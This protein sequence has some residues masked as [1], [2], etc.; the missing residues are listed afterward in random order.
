M[1][2]A[3]LLWKGFL[4]PWVLTTDYPASISRS[5][6]EYAE[7]QLGSPTTISVDVGKNKFVLARVVL[8]ADLA[9]CCELATLDSLGEVAWRLL[10]DKD[11]HR[12]AT[13]YAA[14]EVSV[15]ER[16]VL[17][18]ALRAAKAAHLRRES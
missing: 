8:T 3:V 17:G 7:G 4:P 15:V 1:S 6:A 12:E 9:V 11:C 14:P 16:R 10:S 5:E 18:W 13:D 2:R